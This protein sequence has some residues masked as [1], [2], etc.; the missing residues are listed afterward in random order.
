MKSRGFTLV[1]LLAVIV[2]LAVIALVT[3]PNIINLLNDSKT[4]LSETQ[5]QQ[6]LKAARLYGNK[7][8]ILTDGNEPSEKELTIEQ[9][10]NYGYLDDSVYDIETN[11]QINCYKIMVEWDGKKF[12]YSLAEEV[13]PEG[14]EVTGES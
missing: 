6:I 4:R 9:L 8:I 1:E 3:A 2:V 13:C 11:K 10:I 7:N 12:N 5:E 14:G